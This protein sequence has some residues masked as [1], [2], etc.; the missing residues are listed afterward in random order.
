MVMDSTFGTNKHGYSLFAVLA[1]GEQSQGVPVA[2]LITRSET[3]ESITVALEQFVTFLDAG[4]SSESVPIRPSTV[5]TD[6]SMSEQAACSNVFPDAK[7]ALCAYHVRTAIQKTLQQKLQGGGEQKKAAFVAMELFVR[8]VMY[9]PPMETLAATQAEAQ[10]RFDVFRS[11]Y[12][13]V[14]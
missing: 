13:A 3:T 14:Q 6:D 12:V 9:L 8:E 4:I 11:T 2:F 5:I 1:I 10:R 7:Q